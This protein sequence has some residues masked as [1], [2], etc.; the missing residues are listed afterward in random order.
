M[1]LLQLGEPRAGTCH[2]V[3]Y[4]QEASMKVG[5]VAPERKG[6]LYAVSKTGRLFLYQCSGPYA[7]GCIQEA[8]A[9]LQSGAVGSED[10]GEGQVWL[11][12]WRA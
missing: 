2:E 6:C 11:R 8:L 4:F 7:F 12:F 5:F 1:V 10:G 9:G 3:D